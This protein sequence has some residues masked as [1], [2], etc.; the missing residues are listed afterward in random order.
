MIERLSET[1][2]SKFVFSLTPLESQVVL[3]EHNKIKRTKYFGHS[4]N[5]AEYL[6]N[7]DL[8]FYYF[9]VSRRS[10]WEGQQAEQRGR[11]GISTGLEAAAHLTQILNRT[12]KICIM[13]TL[14]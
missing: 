9:T 2:N 12:G 14:N 5:V 7:S 13:D 6:C 8:S 1:D 4:H 3:E 11:A 10:T